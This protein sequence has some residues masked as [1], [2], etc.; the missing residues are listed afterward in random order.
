M[1]W[2]YLTKKTF[3]ML[4]HL[5]HWLQYRQ[6]RTWI[7][8]NLCYQTI[9]CDTGQHSQFLRCFLLYIPQIWEK[10]PI[11]PFLR[12]SVKRRVKMKKFRSWVQPVYRVILSRSSGDGFAQ[13]QNCRI[14]T[15]A[16][17]GPI[18][19]FV[20]ILGQLHWLQDESNGKTIMTRPR[21]KRWW[22]LQS[23]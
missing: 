4:W 16:S 9:N 21:G 19:G 20:L 11:F 23:Q 12:T 1:R 18:P 13:S 15:L 10:A 14:S 5:R 22:Y 8:D 2:P 6:L 17:R 7:H 3:A